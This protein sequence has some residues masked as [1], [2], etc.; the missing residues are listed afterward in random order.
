MKRK[1]K[2]GRKVTRRVWIVLNS[3]NAFYGETQLNKACAEFS[4]EDS[5]E[6]VPYGAPH[7]IVRAIL[8]YT[9]PV[10]P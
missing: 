6:S 2:R 1:Q 8:I 5:D 7:K 4:R 9:K 10:K 3:L